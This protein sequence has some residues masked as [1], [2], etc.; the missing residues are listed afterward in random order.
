MIASVEAIFLSTFVLVSQNRSARISER[1]A[2]LDL[3]INLLAEHELT[4]ILRMVAAISTK[5]D[6]PIPS[7]DIEVLKEVVDAERVL[8]HIENAKQS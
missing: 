5:L 1:R 8:D 3:Q 4:E 2:E 6:V 7:G